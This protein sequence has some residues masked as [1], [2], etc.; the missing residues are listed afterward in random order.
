MERL[1]KRSKQ[2]LICIRALF[3]CIDARIVDFLRL[4][5]YDDTNP[6]GE[7]WFETV[8]NGAVFFCSLRHETGIL[9]HTAWNGAKKAVKM[10]V[11]KVKKRSPD[12]SKTGETYEGDICKK[13]K[14]YEKMF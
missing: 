12:A 2:G 5:R 1:W 11:E 6:K 7:D 8:V 4:K 13:R 3:S 10:A 9:R 14:P